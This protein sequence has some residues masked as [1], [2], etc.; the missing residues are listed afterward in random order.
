MTLCEFLF[1]NQRQFHASRECN[2]L[3]DLFYFRL[4]LLIRGRMKIFSP[5]VILMHIPSLFGYGKVP[6]VLGQPGEI[7]ECCKAQHLAWSKESACLG[8]WLPSLINFLTRRTSWKAGYTQLWLP[9]AQRI[10]VLAMAGINYKIQHCSTQAFL[11]LCW[12][13]QAQTSWPHLSTSL[14]SWDA[15]LF[16]ERPISLSTQQIHSSQVY[17]SPSL[18]DLEESLQFYG[19]Y[20]ETQAVMA[21]FHLSEGALFLPLPS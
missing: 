3:Q 10:L 5:C 14:R 19:V 11:L 15:L 17:K 20:L 9:Q 1:C 7:F 12:M 8:F 2:P 16:L 18:P 6:P 4:C 13:L 21:L